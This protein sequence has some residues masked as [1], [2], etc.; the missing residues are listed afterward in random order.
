MSEMKGKA[1]KDLNWWERMRARWQVYV[2]GSVRLSPPIGVTIPCPEC[3]T[4]IEKVDIFTRRGKTHLNPCCHW[5]TNEH[6]AKLMRRY[7]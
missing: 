4:P 6:M 2:R 3:L 7:S 5:I 1:L